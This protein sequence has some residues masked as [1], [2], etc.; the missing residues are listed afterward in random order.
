MIFSCQINKRGRLAPASALCSSTSAAAAELGRPG[1]KPPAGPGLHRLGCALNSFRRVG[2]ARVALPLELQAL[3]PRPSPPRGAQFTS[4]PPPPTRPTGASY[5]AHLRERA[6]IVLR[7]N[8]ADLQ[9]AVYAAH[10]DVE[11]AAEGT[12]ELAGWGVGG[13]D[14]MLR[15]PAPQQLRSRDITVTQGVGVLTS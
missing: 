13:T 2:G 14:D 15:V 9:G 12:E 5:P 11:K 3:L 4:T 10:Q 7:V 8:L 1:W 6:P